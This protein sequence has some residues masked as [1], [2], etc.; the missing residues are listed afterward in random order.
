[1]AITMVGFLAASFLSPALGFGPI[2]LIL[3]SWMALLIN[4]AALGQGLALVPR[5]WR[6]L[7]LFGAMALAESP[8][9]GGA[10]RVSNLLGTITF[11]VA[12]PSIVVGLALGQPG[13]LRQM[14]RGVI[15]SFWVFSIATLVYGLGAGIDLQRDV[16][17]VPDMQKNGVGAIYEMLFL[18]AFASARGNVLVQLAALLPAP[19]ALLITGSKTAI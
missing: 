3:L 6:F 14:E 5:L 15:A 8:P 11:V 16:I 19:P 4:R 12:I 2:G 10:Y 18:Y 7:L 9:W 17:F 1:M 13:A